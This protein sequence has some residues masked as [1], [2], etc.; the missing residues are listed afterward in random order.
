MAIGDRIKIRREELGLTQ[1]QLADRLGYKS[2][3][4]INK[5]EMGI[6]DVGQK[7]VPHFAKALETS[8]EY[9]M[10][11]DD[12][13]K[14][15]QHTKYYDPEIAELTQDLFE[16]HYLRALLKS[17]KGNDTKNIELVTEF[18]EKMKGTNIDG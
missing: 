15:Q 4:A 9:L 10:E 3:S 5:I 12:V 6:N 8:I 18:L 13:E 2:K 17:A 11:M 16:N 1:Q 7:K 14:N